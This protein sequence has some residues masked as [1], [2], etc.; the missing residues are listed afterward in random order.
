MSR[1]KEKPADAII[2]F[3]AETKRKRFYQKAKK[4]IQDALS[5]RK[6]FSF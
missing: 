3:A 6:V 4:D 2:R 5:G 1:L